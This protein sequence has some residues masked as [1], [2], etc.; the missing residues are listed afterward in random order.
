LLTGGIEGI[1]TTASK[2]LSGN[3]EWGISIS[4]G[5]WAK[6]QFAQSNP[7]GRSL[8]VSGR[9]VAPKKDMLGQIG[10]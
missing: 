5:F 10:D 7:T 8:G 1:F 9:F 4:A 3:T 6:W 2:T